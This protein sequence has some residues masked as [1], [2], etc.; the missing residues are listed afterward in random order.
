MS[1]KNIAV[2]LVRTTHPGI[3]GATARAMANMGLTDLRLVDPAGYPGEEATA[4][5]VGAFE[6]L[7]QASVYTSLDDAI[8]D[9]GF[10]V[11]ATAR[12]RRIAWPCSEPE[13]AMKIALGHSVTTNVAILFGQEASGLTNEEL[14]RCHLHVRIPVDD[15]HPSLNLASAVLVF[16][17]ELRRL[18]IGEDISIEDRE[19]AETVLARGEQ[20]KDFFGHLE[21]VLNEIEFLKHPSSRLLRKIKRIFS[22][23]PLE[24]QEIHILR[25]ILTSV[26]HACRNSENSGKHR[27]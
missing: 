20:V 4:R 25:G 11:G 9:A 17:Y 3:I 1:L 18:S 10:V 27:S 16:C 22:K 6:L 12:P 14:D 24:E 2:V 23:R 13:A 8:A 15:R 7:E 26:Q 21:T 19:N 5:A